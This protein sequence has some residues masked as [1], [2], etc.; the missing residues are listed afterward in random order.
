MKEPAL[1]YGKKKLSLTGLG[2]VAILIKKLGHDIPTSPITILKT[3]NTPIRIS[4][5]FHHFSLKKRSSGQIKKR[6]DKQGIKSHI[7][8]QINIDGTQ[9]FKSNYLDLLPILVR[10]TNSLNAR[11]FVV[12]LFIGKGKPP[13]L[14]DYLKPFLEELIALQS[15][16]LQLEDICYS[17]EVSSFVCNAPA[18]ACIS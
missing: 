18:R 5:H 2:E 3:K 4:K 7:K 17:I 11:P 16:G 6:N 15:E 1:L 14:E 10:V 9:S 13:N 12:S 8:I